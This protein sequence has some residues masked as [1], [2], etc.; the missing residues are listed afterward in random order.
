MV[1]DD[2]TQKMLKAQ[3]TYNFHMIQRRG[4]HNVELLLDGIA[5]CRSQKGW[6]KHKILSKFVR[7]ELRV[8]RYGQKIS[9]LQ[10]CPRP[11]SGATSGCRVSDHPGLHCRR[12]EM[13]H[14]WTNKEVLTRLQRLHFQNK[15]EPGYVYHI[16]VRTNLNTQSCYERAKLARVVLKQESTSNIN[17][18]LIR[19]KW[20]CL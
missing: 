17:F 12:N 9:R 4:T 11:P 6:N 20:E 15:M 13:S 1:Q 10:F 3:M 5:I 2:V 7:N 18:Y 8:V 19:G 16:H 14:R